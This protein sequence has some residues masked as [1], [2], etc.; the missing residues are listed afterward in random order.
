MRL[1][2]NTFKKEMVPLTSKQQQDLDNAARCHICDGTFC[3]AQT[4]EGDKCRRTHWKGDKKVRDHCHVIGQIHRRR[5]L[6]LQPEL[7]TRNK[8]P[9]HLSQPRNSSKATTLT[10]SCKPLAS[11][12]KTSASFPATWKNTCR[13]PSTETSSSLTAFSAWTTSRLRVWQAFSLMT[14]SRSSSVQHFKDKDKLALVKRKGIYP[15]DYMDSF[16]KFKET[17]L[18]RKEAFFSLLSDESISDE[19]YKYA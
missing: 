16:N 9:R 13:S 2:T 10:S 5:P 19:D 3:S 8:N 14:L 4:E 7:P 12:R 1:L 15:Y 18:P 6:R 11:S 17:Q